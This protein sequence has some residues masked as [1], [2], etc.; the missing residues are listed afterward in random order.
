MPKHLEAVVRRKHE[1]GSSTTSARQAELAI[2]QERKLQAEAKKSEEREKR[3]E[4]FRSLWL[5]T[6]AGEFGD[7]L[8]AIRSVRAHQLS[9][10]GFL[11]LTLTFTLSQKEP[12]LGADGGTRLPLFIDALTAGSEVFASS[13]SVK[14]DPTNTT[15][16]VSLA[17]N[18]S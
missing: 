7:E 5:K 10:I 16:E 4:A 2:R 1:H 15:D 17:M 18:L 14:S 8:D 11:T 6:V 12:T 3:K 13:A 9:G